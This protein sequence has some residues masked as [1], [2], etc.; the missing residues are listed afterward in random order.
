MANE[1]TNTITFN[2]GDGFDDVT[3]H[4]SSSDE[5]GDTIV[6]GPGI[7]PEELRVQMTHDTEDVGPVLVKDINPGS[8]SSRPW[9]ITNV[10]GNVFFRAD[11]GVHGYE[12]WKTDGSSV[13]THM[14]LTIGI[15]DDEGLVIQADG[16]D[17]FTPSDLAVK[18]FVFADGTVLTLEDILARGYSVEGY[19][20]GDTGDDVLVGGDTDDEIYANGGNDEVHAGAGDDT[21]N[22]GSGDD[23]VFAGQ[24]NDDT[25][26]GGAGWDW[27]DGQSG[28]DIIYGEAGMDFLFGGA[29]NDLLDGG[30]FR[31]ELV[32]GSG[33]DTYVVDNR[34]DAVIERY[35]EGIDTVR[36]PLS[37]GL[38]LNLEDLTLTGTASISG[39]G[40]SLSNILMGNSGANSLSGGAGDDTLLG[41]G[42]NDKLY[43]GKGSDTYML[44]HGSGQ[45]VIREHRFDRNSTDVLALLINFN[46]PLIKNGIKRIA[47]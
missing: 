44:N 15:G 2:R 26:Y 12:L 16:N 4:F 30:A 9:F 28:N 38:G 39:T 45:D 19:Q 46:V 29:G 36:S 24:G 11:D 35:N 13:N 23:T 18:R 17:E 42:G 34:S 3:S 7:T 33:D 8:G 14:E 1:G 10:D 21:I 31:D 43:G 40:N 20:E 5:D 47:L 41:G 27:L 22:A 25:I 6:F 32:G 37:Y